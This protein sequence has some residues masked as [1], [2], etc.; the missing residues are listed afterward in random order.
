MTDIAYA[1]KEC[2]RCGEVKRAKD[3]HK[4]AGSKDG[5]QNWCK[6]CK[7]QFINE[8][9]AANVERVRRDVYKANLRRNYGLTL[10]EY[11]ELFA[12][13]RG[14]CAICGSLET[15]KNRDGSLRRLHVDH[16]HHTG[17][18][19][20]LLCSACNSVLG[21]IEAKPDRLAAAARYLEEWQR[22]TES[23][24]KRVANH[25]LVVITSLIGV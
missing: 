18:I 4:A 19:R 3:F 7:H 10:D 1:T 5:L 25:Y 20:G 13:Q 24:A 12:R 22:R 17:A 11:E 14:L 15:A 9:R 16:D 21:Y 6:A 2:P 23:L 8:W